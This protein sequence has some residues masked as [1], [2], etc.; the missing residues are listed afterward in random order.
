MLG[1]GDDNMENNRDVD[2]DDLRHVLE[3]IAVSYSL[4]NALVFH[5]LQVVFLNLKRNNYFERK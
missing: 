1:E 4:R 2:K 5:N 3:I